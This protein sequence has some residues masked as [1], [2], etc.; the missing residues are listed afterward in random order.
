MTTPSQDLVA[1]LKDEGN[2]H[3]GN[4]N[5]RAALACYQ[6]ALEE[7][8]RLAN[9]KQPSAPT[10]VTL[11]ALYSNMSACHV[12][13][14]NA[15]QALCD[16]ELAVKHHPKW[17]KGYFRCG[18]A[19]SAMFRNRRALDAL[20]QALVYGP[21]SADIEQEIAA[22]RKKLQRS[23][24]SEATEYKPVSRPDGFEVLAFKSGDEFAKWFG[25]NF[26]PWSE[27][28]P[29]TV[30]TSK[31]LESWYTRRQTTLRDKI[32]TLVCK[33]SAHV[34][35]AAEG[36]PRPRGIR[37]AD[38][39]QFSVVEVPSQGFAESFAS[40]VLHKLGLPFRIAYA[41]NSK[42]QGDNQ[43]A[44]YFMVEV[45]NGLAGDRWQM[46]AVGPVVVYRTDG[47]DVTTV[48][49]E[50]LWDFF[51][52]LLDDFGEVKPPSINKKYFLNWQENRIRKQS[53]YQNVKFLERDGSVSKSAVTA[54]SSGNNDPAA[55]L[56]LL[57]S[58]PS[59]KKDLADDVASKKIPDAKKALQDAQLAMIY[60]GRAELFISQG[61]AFLDNAIEDL[62]E[63]KKLM[64]DEPQL[65]EKIASVQSKLAE[66]AGLESMD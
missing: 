5:P 50:A 45:E 3:F 65:K 19:L 22:V 41:P 38:K 59:L 66:A 31:D 26:L 46:G 32:Q 53:R 13:V 25:F 51:S 48:E 36:N 7:G 21:G 23:G 52:V 35:F 9:A 34:S 17:A 6:A 4:Q 18:V 60:T 15:E 43:L 40:P 16:A 24:C 42:R 14:G 28:A 27:A 20:R 49:V 8:T 2:A 11:A 56:N 57:D 10:G 30:R 47:Q 33:R 44:T 12:L 29:P 1:R 58:I 37:V 63:V 61:G 55:R 39:L 54:G 62:F 64:P